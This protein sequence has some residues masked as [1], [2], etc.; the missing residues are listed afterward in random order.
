MITELGKKKGFTRPIQRCVPESYVFSLIQNATDNDY[1]P[2][3]QY[4][5]FSS[6]PLDLEQDLIL[7]EIFG[8]TV[9][10]DHDYPPRNPPIP[11]RNVNIT[12]VVFNFVFD[13]IEDWIK[14][15]DYGIGTIYISTSQ[16]LLVSLNSVPGT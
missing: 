12:P 16:H 2:V 14:D 4:L 3:V 10:I 6:Y 5:V 7:F 15:T 1:Y 9:N 8:I 11:L 13:K